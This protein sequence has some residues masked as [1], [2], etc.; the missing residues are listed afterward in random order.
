M[1]EYPSVHRELRR[2]ARILGD[3]TWISSADLRGTSL[4]IEGQAANASAVMQQLLDHPAYAHVKASAA[5]QKVRSG[6]ERFVLD[7]T[8]AP[9][10]QAQ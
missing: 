1:A 6:L 3:D 2:L 4:R 9:E 8:L 7:L 5:F 10:A